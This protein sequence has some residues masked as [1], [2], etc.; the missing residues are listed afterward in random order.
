MKKLLRR[1]VSAGLREGWIRGVQDGKRTWIVV[2]GLA[3]L[4]H[5]AGRWLPRKTDVVFSEK[6]APGEAFEITH[7]PRS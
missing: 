3:I 5:L 2:F 1:L 4:G 7:L 6:L